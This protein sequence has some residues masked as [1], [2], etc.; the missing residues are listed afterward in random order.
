MAGRKILDLVI[1][2]RILVPQPN[3]KKTEN[4]MKKHVSLDLFV[5]GIILLLTT[6]VYA[7]VIDGN[8][9]YPDMMPSVYTQDE[10]EQAW[11]NYQSMKEE[12]RTALFEKIK[13]NWGEWKTS[14]TIFF[15]IYCVLHAIDWSQTLG[16]A[17]HPDRYYEI[18]P[19]IGRHP[20]T[21]WV[22]IY[23][24]TSLAAVYT[25]VRAMPP[26]HRWKVWLALIG[27]KSALVALNFSV[28]L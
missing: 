16:I 25:G 4:Q 14:D 22:N 11:N 10:I 26:K 8:M 7:Q 12:E 9:K 15:A 19:V 27:I 24:G 3:L 6:T 2:V 1:W 17:H 18:N 28:G 20:S 13:D 21:G 23:M 5:I